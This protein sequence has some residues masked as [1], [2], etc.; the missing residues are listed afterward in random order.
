MLL[1]CEDLLALDG[2]P[3]LVQRCRPL[4]LDVAD[5][6]ARLVDLDPD[7][8]LDLEAQGTLLIG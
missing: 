1:H 5:Q 8:D 7:P 6:R 4:Q 2:G 3:E